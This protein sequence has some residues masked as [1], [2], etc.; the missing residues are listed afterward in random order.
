M[1]Y[2]KDLRKMLFG[3]PIKFNGN[4][5]IEQERTRICDYLIQETT[6]LAKELPTH[7]VIPFNPVPKKDFKNSK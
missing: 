3:K 5:P 2:C 1:Y 7:K 6:A 4:N